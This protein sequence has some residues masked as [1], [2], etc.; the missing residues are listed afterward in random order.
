MFAERLKQRR[1]EL[2]LTQL[3]A[4]R[5]IDIAPSSYSA[6]E[7]GKQH[8]KIDVLVRICDKF[9]V[10]ADWLLGVEQPIRKLKNSEILL[11]MMSLRSSGARIF[12]TSLSYSDL[13]SVMG[14]NS[15]YK[16]DA[17]VALING[18]ILKASWDSL[19]TME[20]NVKENKM[21]EASLKTWLNAELK[22]LSEAPR[23]I[24]QPFNK[25]LSQS[26]E[27]LLMTEKLEVKRPLHDEED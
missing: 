3:E 15:Y 1:E 18:D 22:E 8:P 7:T 13:G 23:S 21:P 12:T 17:L 4:A 16:Q 19:N 26:I 20:F 25:Y 10:S 24:S 27:R 9:N 14:K 6:Y 2:R 11:N 5:E